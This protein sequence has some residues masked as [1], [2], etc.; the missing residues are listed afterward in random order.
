MLTPR[1]G[2]GVTAEE[3]QERALGKRVVV[4]EIAVFHHTKGGFGD[5]D[6]FR[7]QDRAFREKWGLPQPGALSRLKSAALARRKEIS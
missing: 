3:I 4:D 2:R 5:I 1:G 6:T 7:A